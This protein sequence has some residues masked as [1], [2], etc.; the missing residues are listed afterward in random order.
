MTA[1][2]IRRIFQALLTLIILTVIVFLTMR[3][4]P[5]DPILIY[6]SQQNIQNVTQEQLDDLRHKYGLDKS[7][8]MQ[9]V[10]WISN[11]VRGDLG[12]SITYDSKVTDDIKK[13]LPVSLYLGALGFVVGSIIGVPAGIIAAVRR[14]RWLDNI[15]TSVGN[16][17]MTI[18]IFWLGVLLIYVFGLKLGVLPVFGYTSPFED[19]GASIQQIILP[20][21]C[22]A[23]PAIAG[24]I[25]LVRSSMLEVMRQDY[26]RTAWSKGLKE[27]V[28]IVRHALR[29]GVIPIITM[30][31]MTLASIVGGQVF[32]E[33]IFNIPGMGRLAVAAVTTK[34][35]AE[36]QGIMLVVGIAVLLINLLVD[37]S[38]GWLDPRVRYV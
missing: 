18:P 11:A 23:V 17:G 9:F 27:N 32:I 35:Y 14:G 22:L 33:T 20:V 7:L 36:V 25:R 37:L 3:L 10:D 34:D 21:I 38:Y 30:K 26:I 31:G 19:F 16:L 6:V 4:L 2:I 24:D 28:L 13:R 29:N 1:Y 8:P 12:T 5:G 15:I